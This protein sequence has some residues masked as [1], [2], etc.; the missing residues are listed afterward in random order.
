M[1]DNARRVLETP[2]PD[3]KIRTRKGSFG[4]ELAY[5]EVHNYIARL[6]E[7]FAGDWSFDVIEY[8]IM[9]SEVVVLGK[10]NAGEVSK[11]AFGSSSITTAR[12]SGERVS[13]GD[14]LKAAASDAL[15][16]AG[17]LLGLGL[18]LY[19]MGNRDASH[20]ET[21]PFPARAGTAGNGDTLTSRQHGA[22]V[23]LALKAGYSEAELK[24]RI[25]DRFGAP[26]EKLDRRT[27]SEV[28][29]QLSNGNGKAAGG[30]L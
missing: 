11:A 18:H 4:K 24:T 15:K 12:D 6:N 22:I 13:I 1:N 28:I 5:A 21:V 27:A 23:A 16:K 17:S 26:L 10:L 8:R 9:D 25:L 2:F 30:A 29:S 3:E 20:S 19:G 14:D 7:A